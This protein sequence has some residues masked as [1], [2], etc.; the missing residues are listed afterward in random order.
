MI[1]EL[2]NI[3]EKERISFKRHF[4]RNVV[5]EIVFDNLNKESLLKNKDNIQK[6]FK[7]LGFTKFGEMKQIEFKMNI[8]DDV[9]EQIQNDNEVIGLLLFDDNRK[10][11]IELMSNK[12]IIS[13]FSRF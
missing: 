12:I 3:E 2:I 5:L 6:Q 10:I 4:I 1:K 13:I 9:P 8:E 11:R 7:N